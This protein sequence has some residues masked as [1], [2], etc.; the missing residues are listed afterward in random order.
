M[1]QTLAERITKKAASLVGGS[2]PDQPPADP[3][4]FE[5]A[6][7]ALSAARDRLAAAHQ[8]HQDALAAAAAGNPSSHRK[9]R[10]ELDAAQ[11]EHQMAGEIFEAAK[12]AHDAGQ[13][14]AARARRVAAVE[15]LAKLRYEV[16]ARLDAR[17][18]ELAK[19]YAERRKLD[20]ELMALVPGLLEHDLGY[21]QDAT[22]REQLAAAG[23]PGQ[24]TLRG[25][26]FPSCSVLARETGARALA[27]IK[28]G[29]A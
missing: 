14:S 18:A 9:T 13:S 28:G 1:S 24:K 6:E 15:R 10:L 7:A 5:K 12:R 2:K 11:A 3:G 8:A 22:F 26:A 16:G 25:D 21:V 20:K 17:V 27:A 19:D 29:K 4:A 23:L